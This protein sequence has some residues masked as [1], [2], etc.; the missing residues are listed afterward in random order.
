MRSHHSKDG[1]VLAF[2]LV[3]LAI[4]TIVLG[5]LYT[6]V[7]MTARQSI[8][9]EG[10][11]TCRLAAQSAIEYVKPAIEKK[12]QDAIGGT[13]VKIGP[14]S[15]TAY[16]WFNLPNGGTTLGSSRAYYTLPSTNIV[17]NGCEVK[18]QFGPC[19]QVDNTSSAIVSLIA[20]ARR[21][22]PNGT[23][24]T[25]VIE[26]LFRFG[27]GRSK[28]FDYAY[29]VNNYGWFKGSG[30]TANGDVRANG[31]M[32]LDANCTIN[33][34]VYAA[35]NQELG[36]RGTV[37]NYGK[38][39]SRSAYWSSSKTSTQS[40]PTSPTSNGGVTWAGGYEAPVSA[41]T[42]AD[43]RGRI[44]DNSSDAKYNSDDRER[45]IV[46]PWIGDLDQYV[47][48][49]REMGGTLSGGI[50]YSM[51]T[52]GTVVQK[53]NDTINAHFD[54]AGP[55]GDATLSDRG[56][57]VLEGTAANPIR[58]NGPVV[59]DSDVVIKGYVTGQGTI[60]SGRN[61]HIVGNIQYKNPPSWRHPDSNP[62]ATAKANS[63]KDL[64]GFAAKGNIVL[65]DASNSSI[66]TST[67]KSYLSTQPYVQQ[68]ACDNSDKNI[69]YPRSIEYGY[70]RNESK[71]CGDY[72]QVDGGSLVTTTTKKETQTTTT[73]VYNSKTRKWENK[74]TTTEITKNVFTDSHTRHYYNSVVHNSLLKSLYSANGSGFLITKIDGVL[75]N[76]HG[77]FGM[78]G[79]CTINGSLVCRNEGIQYSS[80]FNINHDIRLREDSAE[81]IDNKV[82]M[83]LG[84]A[85]PGV[86][87]WHELPESVTFATF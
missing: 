46:M 61:I 35:Y 2:A 77:T 50:R 25:S 47:E 57:I 30:N 21:L 26:E 22:N 56:S 13:E 59:I 27:T 37:Q 71:F 79:N 43:L 32:Y 67:I 78:I 87:S 73:P 48:Y 70:T 80:Q 58:I 29:F 19:R 66:F 64:V 28:V 14:R 49:S 3:M 60:Y 68:Y 81:G 31:N 20:R 23:V 42:T 6:L 40:R 17:I 45:G 38:M 51:N 83:P 52:D 82:G 63:T 69:G 9:Y 10:R 62:E 7:S 44:V 11:N 12:F 86:I 18:L 41:A 65:G 74:T 76:N 15:S 8:I 39:D 36:V 4:A 16:S 5:G 85:A 33:G 72:T 55:S 75:Y 34:Y 53:Q 24:S 54:G 1:F 84:A